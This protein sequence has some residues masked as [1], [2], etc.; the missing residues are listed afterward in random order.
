M[1]PLQYLH[2]DTLEHHKEKSCINID[3]GIMKTQTLKLDADTPIAALRIACSL[4]CYPD[5]LQRQSASGRGWHFQVPSIVTGARQNLRLRK[6]L[7]DCTGRCKADS[8]RL[9]LR[10]KTN[11]LFDAKAGKLAGRWVPLNISKIMEGL[12]LAS[13]E[14]SP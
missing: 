9:K 3:R 8:I 13:T 7:H 5:A 2:A 12:C 14:A 6:A 10:Q 4:S 1:V 11:V